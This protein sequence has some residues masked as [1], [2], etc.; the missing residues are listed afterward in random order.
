MEY[1]FAPMEGISDAVYRKVHREFFPGIDRYYTPFL[2]PNQNRKFSTKELREILP[3]WNAGI[4]LVPQLLCKNP[5]DFLWA[6]EEIAALGYPEVNLNLGCPSG[7]VTAKKKGAGLLGDPDLLDEFLDTVCRAMPL[8]LSVKTRLGMAEPEE[9]TRILRIYNRYP[10][11]EVILHPRTR[12]EFYKGTVHMEYFGYALE[13][14]RC[15]VCY[16]GDLRTPEDIARLQEQ[17]PAAGSVMIGRG[18][19][20]NPALVREIRTGEKL[21]KEELFRFHEALF[22]AYA[23]AFGSAQSA[24]PRMKE[25]WSYLIRW[26]ADSERAEKALRKATRRE[27][28]TLAVSQIKSLQFRPPVR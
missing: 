14:S 23:L 16:N 22:E 1:R 17:Y 11:C 25:I 9:F 8:K 15:P 19:V 18:L 3:E 21:T 13:H 6:A 4:P 20:E 5:Q 7:T 2:S 28:F 27:D 24:V 12:P 10:L 26:F